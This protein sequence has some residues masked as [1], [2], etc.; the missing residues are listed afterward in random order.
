[1]SKQVLFCNV[2]NLNWLF[3]KLKA[4]TRTQ[5]H[6]HTHIHVHVHLR[7]HVHIQVDQKH[8]LLHFLCKCA[9]TGHLDTIVA[10]N[11]AF[12]YHLRSHSRDECKESKCEGCFFT[13][14]MWKTY[15]C[16]KPTFF[17]KNVCKKCM[18]EV[19]FLMKLLKIGERKG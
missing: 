3:L 18:F 16:I 8:L 14:A 9:E 10:I 7:L 11:H 17:V 15:K 12:N 13:C 4:H 6:T 5:T 2:Y 1:M 19:L